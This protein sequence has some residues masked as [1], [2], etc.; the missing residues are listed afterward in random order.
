M[1]AVVALLN[2]EFNCT[3]VASMDRKVNSDC[4]SLSIPSVL[5]S[6]VEDLVVVY[7][8]PVNSHMICACQIKEGA[9]ISKNTQSESEHGVYRKEPNYLNNILIWSL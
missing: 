7:F 9:V 4:N 2:A 1:Y 3:T 5:V 6:R 8:L